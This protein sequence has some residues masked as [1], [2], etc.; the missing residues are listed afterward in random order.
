MLREKKSKKLYRPMTANLGNFEKAI[1]MQ[2]SVKVHELIS[3][4]CTNL[5]QQLLSIS[6][7]KIKG[8]KT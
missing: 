8:S 1:R 7:A 6:G 3:H 5:G 4:L 2:H